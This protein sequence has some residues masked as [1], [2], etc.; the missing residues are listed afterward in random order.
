M[1][2]ERLF[3]LEHLPRPE[4]GDFAW[5]NIIYK[6]LRPGSRRS[7][8]LPTA[9]TAATATT[10]AATAT[11]TAATATTTA[12]TATTTAAAARLKCRFLI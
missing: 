8:F 1:F 6:S 10:T 11:T 5:Q 4:V 2:W 9:A 3:S 7:T 12:A